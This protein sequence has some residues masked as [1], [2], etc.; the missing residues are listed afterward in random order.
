MTENSNRRES[1]RSR[2]TPRVRPGPR[3]DAFILYTVGRSIPKSDRH[4][5]EVLLETFHSNEEIQALCIEANHNAERYLTLDEDGSNQSYKSA[6]LVPEGTLLA[7]YSGPLERVRPGEED[8]LNHS[9]TQGRLEWKYD[10][11][12]DLSLIHISE[13]TRRS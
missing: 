10:L 8:V 9:M 12:V 5:L 1:L 3:A 4:D 13:P 2:P 11:R 6:I 7:V